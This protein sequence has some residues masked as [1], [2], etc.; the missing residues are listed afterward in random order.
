MLLVEL[1]M[2]IAFVQNVR[3]TLRPLSGPLSCRE[4]SH[5]PRGLRHVKTLPTA[6]RAMH[7]T[8]INHTYSL[9]RKHSNTIRMG[10]PKRVFMACGSRI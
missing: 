1:S 4:Y 7:T 5:T 3:D 2:S 8:F 6:M 9:P 10:S